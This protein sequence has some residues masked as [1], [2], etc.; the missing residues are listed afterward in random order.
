MTRKIFLAAAFAVSVLGAGTAFA[1]APTEVED[2]R[3]GNDLAAACTALVEHDASEDGQLASKACSDFLGSMVKKVYEA[4]E[5]GAPTTFSRVGPK[6]DTT[7][8]FK[9]EGKLSFVDFAKL[10]L[11]YHGSHP[12]L[13]DRPAYETGA[14]VLS[15]NYPCPK[16]VK[17]P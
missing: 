3:T 13:D 8:C 9:L 16:E 1:A 4:T 2:I 7:L 5:A 10:V 14:W 15:N 11:A 17:A 12:E 6:Q